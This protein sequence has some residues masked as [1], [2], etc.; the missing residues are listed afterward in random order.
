LSPVPN[1]KN[2]KMNKI[3]SIVSLSGLALLVACGPSAEDQANEKARQDS[4]QAARED[5]ITAAMEA[6]KAAAAD[7]AAAYQA[8]QAAGKPAATEAAPAAE[9]APAKE[10]S[11]KVDLKGGDNK[12]TNKVNVKG[13]ETNEDG[14]KAG[15]LKLK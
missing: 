12:N 8:G 1:P 10:T 5:S 7:A 13:Q 2:L 6:E 9:V 15:K 11:P 4:I 14:K 3:L